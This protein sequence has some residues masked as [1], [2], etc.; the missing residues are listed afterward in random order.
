[1][2]VTYNIRYYNAKGPNMA[3]IQAMKDAGT[4]PAEPPAQIEVD[5]KERMFKQWLAAQPPRATRDELRA[6][7]A[8]IKATEDMELVEH[9]ASNDGDDQ[10][11][12]AGGTRGWLG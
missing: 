9:T 8:L 2:K 3:A 7:K 1:M 4:L 10:R 12:S 11:S 5:E 6:A